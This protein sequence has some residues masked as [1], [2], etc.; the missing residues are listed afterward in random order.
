[1][2]FTTVTADARR[3]AGLWPTPDTA[4]DRIVIALELLVA[5]AKTDEDRSRARKALEALGG[6]GRDPSVAVA[7]AAITGQVG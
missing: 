3:L 6:A 1:M 4:A 7:A 2:G 5:N